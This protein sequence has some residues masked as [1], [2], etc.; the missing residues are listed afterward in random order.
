MRYCRITATTTETSRTALLLVAKDKGVEIPVPPG[1][2]FIA[3]LGTEEHGIGAW[4]GNEWLFRTVPLG[5]KAPPFPGPDDEDANLDWRL[6]AQMQLLFEDLGLWTLTTNIA[7]GVSFVQSIGQR[8]RHLP[9]AQEG[10]NP[11]CIADTAE[12]IPMKI[13]HG[14]KKIIFKARAGLTTEWSRRLDPDPDFGLRTVSAAWGTA[15]MLEVLR[16]PSEREPGLIINNER[17]TNTRK[18]GSPVQPRLPPSPPN[19]IGDDEEKF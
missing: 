8:T 9:E 14:V 16:A 6:C 10:M 2:R 13:G 18:S 5:Q 11:I 3:D 12:S 19:K 1:A 7:T 15:D 4:T 17:F